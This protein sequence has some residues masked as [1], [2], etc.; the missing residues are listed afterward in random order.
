[1]CISRGGAGAVGCMRWFGRSL[2]D[3]VRTECS[4]IGDLLSEAIHEPDHL[5]VQDTVVGG[6][7]ANADPVGYPVSRAHEA[8]ND[9]PSFQCVWTL[10]PGFSARERFDGGRRMENLQKFWLLGPDGKP[11]DERLRAV[12][13]RLLPKLRRRFPAIQDEA[14]IQ[15]Q[16]EEAARRFQQKE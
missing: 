10:F 16:D 13:D 5:A 1:M 6:V 12:F 14:E 3:P 4:S 9:G 11:L 8:I 15:N 7:D 2:S